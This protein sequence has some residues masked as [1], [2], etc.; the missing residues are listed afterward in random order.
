MIGILRFLGLLGF[1]VLRELWGS[2]GGGAGD[3]GVEG[4][5]DSKTL[6][7]IVSAVQDFDLSLSAG[8]TA[9]VHSMSGAN[10]IAGEAVGAVVSP[11]RQAVGIFQRDVLQ[12]TN[13]GTR[14]AAIA[15]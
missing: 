11:V 4:V 8:E 10:V 5:V 13:L 9:V 2:Y 7:F 6:C 1:Y 14:A 15:P 3:A 12:R